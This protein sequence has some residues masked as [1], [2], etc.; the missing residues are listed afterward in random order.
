[1][2]NLKITVNKYNIFKE[3]KDFILDFGEVKNA[4]DKTVT[5]L[6]ENIENSELLNINRTCGCTTTNKEI[7]DAHTQ[8]VRIN[9]N[10]CDPTISKALEVVYNNK[11][12][13]IIKIKGKCK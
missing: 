10:Q 1:M 4:E 13:G 6:I 5:L 7:V 9:Y 3:G 12:V 8:A 2:E 11:K